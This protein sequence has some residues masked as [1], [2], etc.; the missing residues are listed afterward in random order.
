MPPP[1]MEMRQTSNRSTRLRKTSGPSLRRN[2]PRVSV[3]LDKYLTIFLSVATQASKTFIFVGEKKSGKSSMITKFLEQQVKEEMPETTA[4]NYSSGIKINKDE[5]KVK[6]NVYE[7]GGGRSFAN[8]LESAM[9][10]E[11]I[12]NTTVVIVIDLSKPGNAI[13][14]LLFWLNAVREQS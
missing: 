11:S 9:V 3:Q 6:V 14:S 8:L 12:Q 2:N 13:D 7:L 4:M 5:K 1:K 10:G